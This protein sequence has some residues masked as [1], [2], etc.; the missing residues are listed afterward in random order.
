MTGA[1][2]VGS[3]WSPPVTQL[4]SMTQTVA[5]QCGDWTGNNIQG[6]PKKGGKMASNKKVEENRPNL[7]FNSTCWEVI[8]LRPFYPLKWALNTNPPFFVTPC[9]YT[10]TTLTLLPGHESTGSPELRNWSTPH[11]YSITGRNLYLLG[12]PLFS[13][14][15][16]GT[17]KP[18]AIIN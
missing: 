6:V 1:I 17:L 18:F 5:G 12:R 3:L 15:K 9:K 16:L 7:K 2:R 11:R 8:D 14:G 4:G 13:V 10:N